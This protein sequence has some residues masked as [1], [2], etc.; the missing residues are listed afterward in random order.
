MS[1][2]VEKDMI[3]PPRN[4]PGSGL[5]NLSP[6]KLLETHTVAEAEAVAGRLSR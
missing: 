3:S 1:V 4:S 5:L 6:D 2:L